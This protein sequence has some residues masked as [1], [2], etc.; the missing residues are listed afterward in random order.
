MRRV[1]RK[2]MASAPPSAARASA[3]SSSDENTGLRATLKPPDWV[4]LI[5][6]TAVMDALELHGKAAQAL[7]RLSSV[8][9]TMRVNPRAR[10]PRGE[11]LRMLDAARHASGA[12]E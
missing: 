1:E 7:D 11:F 6:V 8:K 2:I 10:M 3:P 12:P 5:V 4:S 9:E